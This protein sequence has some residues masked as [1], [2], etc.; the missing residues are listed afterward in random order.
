MQSLPENSRVPTRNGKKI[1]EPLSMGTEGAGGR[2]EQCARLRAP[3]SQSAHMQLWNDFRA[4]VASISLSS[5]L[6]GHHV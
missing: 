1:K 2:E 6:T 5:L 4:Q 3:V